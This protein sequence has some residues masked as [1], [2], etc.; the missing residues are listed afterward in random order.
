MTRIN[1]PESCICCSRR[2]DGLAVGRPERLG[3]FCSECGPDMARIALQM[4][5]SKE[6]DVYEQRAAAAVA[7][8]LPA[9]DFNFPAED[10]PKFIGWTVREF[11]DA[12]RK[13]IE[14]GK[15]PF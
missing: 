8:K 3:W 2:A 13:E 10:L 11:A 14:G 5:Q 4:A 7:E 15:P 6:L 1:N 9:T 12:I